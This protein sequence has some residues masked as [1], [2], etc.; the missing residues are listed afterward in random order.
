MENFI[1][2]E[3]LARNVRVARARLGIS[4][5]ELSDK[6]GIGE[7]TISF[8]ESGKNKAFR[9]ATLYKLANVLQVDVEELIGN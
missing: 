5:K 6:S 8:I 3:R 9:I 2:N 1:N 4:Q 7:T